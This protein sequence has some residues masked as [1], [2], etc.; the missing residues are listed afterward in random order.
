MKSIQNTLFGLAALVAASCAT[1]PVKSAEAPAYTV[2]VRVVAPDGTQLYAEQS[3]IA[4]SGA[5]C[6]K[7]Y[8]DRV[9]D[10]ANNVKQVYEILTCKG[11]KGSIVLESIAGVPFINSIE[12]NVGGKT[13]VQPKYA[14][15]QVIG[16]EE[17]KKVQ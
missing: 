15:S 14:P 16:Y 2:E 12:V 6:K 9:L 7:T 5:G 3:P 11:D 8:Q 17:E 1:V 4:A 10:S 13:K